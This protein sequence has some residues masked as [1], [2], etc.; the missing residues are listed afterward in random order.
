MDERRKLLQYLFI[1]A[2]ICLVGEMA[3]CLVGKGNTTRLNFLLESSLA[4]ILGAFLTR[5]NRK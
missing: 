5:L 4:A 2:V 3:L 1:L